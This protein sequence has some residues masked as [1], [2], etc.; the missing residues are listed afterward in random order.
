MAPRSRRALVWTA[1]AVLTIAMTFLIPPRAAEAAPLLD[2]QQTGIVTN[3]TLTMG[4]ESAQRIAQTVTAGREGALV[5]VDLPVLCAGAADLIIEIRD[6]TTSGLPGATIKSTTTI[7]GTTI[8]AFSGSPTM[9]Q[10]TLAMSVPLTVGERFA[11]VL[12]STGTIAAT[13]SCG[14][15][16]G[17][18]GDT[19]TG[20]DTYF[21]NTLSPSWTCVCVHPGQMRDVPFRTWVEPTVLPGQI[22]FFDGTG[23]G[24]VRPDG[25]GLVSVACTLCQEPNWS[26]NGAKIVFTSTRDGNR[27]IYVMNADGTA[28]TRLTVNTETD[29]HPIWSPNGTKIAF[30]RFDPVVNRL[31]MFTM[32]ADGTGVVYLS[33]GLHHDMDPAWSPDGTKIAFGSYR[34][35]NWEIYTMNANGTGPIRLTTDPGTDLYPAWSPDGTKIAFT[36]D[37]G[38]SSPAYDIY[39]MNASGTGQTRL[40]TDPAVDRVPTWSPDGSKIAFQ[41]DRTAGQ[42]I[43]V[44]NPDGSGETAIPGVISPALHPHWGSRSTGETVSTNVAAGGTATTDTENDGATTSDAFETTVTSP[45]A[46]AVT[47]T[48]STATGAAPSGYSSLGMRVSITAPPATAGSPLVIVFLIDASLIPPG[49]NQNTIQVRRNGVVVPACTGA[50]GT[51]SPD[52]CVS[53]RQ[54]LAGGDVS[55]TILTSSASLWDFT[56]ERFGFGGFEPPMGTMK[57][58]GSTLPIRFRL[59]GERVEV[60]TATEVVN[61]LAPNSPSSRAVSCDTGA[62]LEASGPVNVIGGLH[63][64]KGTRTYSINWKTEKD[65]AGTCRELLL[66]LID[67]SEHTS[68]IQFE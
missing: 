42:L 35:G 24:F 25:S 8:P 40:T 3:A 7:T 31:Q 23:L 57:K 54:L 64:D 50:A 12:R 49:G 52:P 2:Q 26:P 28:Q 29:S 58:A 19:Y 5:R 44:M 56:I 11:I 30:S 37:R 22:V 4:G 68:R 14:I 9:R 66:E 47:I 60:L 15:Y 18:V 55:I 63:L 39:V 51:A 6:V 13:D 20:G 43:Y 61:V 36:S 33:N 10:F 27:E 65:W 34:D 16:R 21:E 46:G 17:P 59:F 45:N 53:S 1:T 38:L 41:S 62:P 48:D 67:G 32:N